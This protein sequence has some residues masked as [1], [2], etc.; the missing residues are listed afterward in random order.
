MGSKPLRRRLPPYSCFRASFLR[1]TMMGGVMKNRVAEVL[2]F[3]LAKV[4]AGI[5]S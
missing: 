5:L 2:D 3:L 4:A 1:S